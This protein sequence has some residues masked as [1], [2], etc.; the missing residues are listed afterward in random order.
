MNKTHTGY[1]LPLDFAELVVNWGF[2]SPPEAVREVFDWLDFDR[3]GKL[4]FEDL[5][6]TAG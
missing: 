1:I 4:T 5:R 3:D 6:A 2:E